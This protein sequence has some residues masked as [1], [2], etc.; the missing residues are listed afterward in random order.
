[1]NKIGETDLEN[2]LKAFVR[3]YMNYRDADS[4]ERNAVAKVWNHGMGRLTMFKVYPDERV[5][6]YNTAL[7]NRTDEKKIVKLER[8]LGGEWTRMPCYYGYPLYYNHS[9]TLNMAREQAEL[10][11]GN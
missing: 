2:I 8:M 3:K 10:K 11:K 1:M 6:V 7:F 9:M 4:W 5:I